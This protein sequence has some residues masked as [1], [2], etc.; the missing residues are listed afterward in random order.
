MVG[1]IQRRPASRL[2]HHLQPHPHQPA[3]HQTDP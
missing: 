3:L 2:A 1:D